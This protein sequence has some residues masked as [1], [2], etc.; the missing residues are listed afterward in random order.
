MNRKAQSEYAWIFS[1]IIGAVIIFLAIYSSGRYIKTAEYK[2]SAEMARELDIL[3]NPFASMGSIATMTLSKSVKMPSEV[4]IEFSCSADEDLEKMSLKAKVG[5]AFSEA[6]EYK[7]KNKYIFSEKLEGKEL[8]IFGKPME[9]PWR[10]DDLIYMLSD[11]YCFTDSVPESIRREISDL[12]SSK[13]LLACTNNSRKVCFGSRSCSINVDY[14]NGI[15]RKGNE[16]LEFSGDALMYAAVFS[17]NSVYKCNLERIMKR[18]DV[19]AD[20]NLQK[21][22]ILQDKGCDTRSLQQTIS[23]LKLTISRNLVNYMGIVASEIKQKNPAECP[24]F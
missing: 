3:L 18:L 9:M 4:R 5:K 13:V 6:A 15:V 20:I 8:W 23:S 21:A 17:D 1:L 7:I 10:V 24:V 22:V 2:T 19:Q 11:E 14:K 16:E 12:K